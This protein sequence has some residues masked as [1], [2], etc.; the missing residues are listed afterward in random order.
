MV[1]PVFYGILFTLALLFAG[2]TGS[3]SSP[4]QMVDLERVTDDHQARLAAL[5][6][7]IRNSKQDDAL[8]ARR[9]VLYLQLQELEKALADA[10]EAVRLS[11]NEPAN[12]FIKAQVLRSLKREGEALSLALQAERNGYHNALLYVL[13]S[14]LYLRLKQNDKARE[15]NNLAYKLSPKD[16]YVLYYRGRIAAAAGDTA[17]AIKFYEQAVAQGP[18]FFEPKREL[19]GIYTLVADFKVAS[20]YIKAAQKQ[21]NKDGLLWY[22]RGRLYQ[23]A[24]KPDSALWNYNKAVAVADSLT[25][26]H[27]RLGYLYYARG[28]YE[29]A[30]KHLTKV[31]SER[32]NAVRF[33]TTLGSIYER[34][35]QYRQALEQYEKLVNLE[36]AY[37][38]A[39]QS[40][41]RIKSRFTSIVADS[42]SVQDEIEE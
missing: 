26:A 12:L 34:T 33:Y 3:D 28:N 32:K 27:S 5:N 21:N 25:D 20:D 22:Y 42:T 8:Y 18:D 39:H 13:L 16:E 19:A 10:N 9:A 2:C 30:I 14:D 29:K 38:Y 24:E 7:A 37:V 17:T 31:E 11:K 35:G 6:E 40:I 41:A 23:A 1:K 15:Y 36:P 4:E